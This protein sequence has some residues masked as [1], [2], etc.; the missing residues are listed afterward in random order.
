M[1]VAELMKRLRGYKKKGARLI[2]ITAVPAEEKNSLIY[3]VEADG[4][5]VNLKVS[6]RKDERMKSIVGIFEY[7]QNYEREASELFGIKFDKKTRRLF[8]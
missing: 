8:T 3:S 4:K 5:I 2:A 7:A 1:S 6:I